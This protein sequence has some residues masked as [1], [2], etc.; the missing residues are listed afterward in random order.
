M[1][2]DYKICPYCGGSLDVGEK[3]D[4]LQEKALSRTPQKGI[5]S[6]KAYIYITNEENALERHT[7]APESR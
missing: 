5:E 3:C 6:T 7:E 4:C 1:R 2:T